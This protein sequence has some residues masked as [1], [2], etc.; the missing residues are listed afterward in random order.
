MSE[1]ITNHGLQKKKVPRHSQ[2]RIHESRLGFFCIH[3]SHTR[4]LP[5]PGSRRTPSRPCLHMKS[6]RVCIK[7]RSPPA[8]LPLKGHVSR[9][10]TVKWP[11]GAM[12]AGS[13]IT[14]CQIPQYCETNR[15][16]P[17]YCVKNKRNTNTGFILN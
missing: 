10:T 1:E 14:G 16:I 8:S 9:H 12:V 5:N 11:I 2:C 6:R 7:T 15:P 17:Q 3:E 4:F 13:H